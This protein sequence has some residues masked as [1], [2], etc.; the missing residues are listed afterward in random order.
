MSRFYTLIGTTVV[1]GLVG[2][3]PPA[4]AQPGTPLAGEERVRRVASAAPGL[5]EGVV[6][7]ERGHPLGGAMVSALGAI[8]ALA[9]TDRDG[10]FVLRA[11]P[12]GAYLVR[13]HLAGFSRSNRQFV[14]VGPGGVARFSVTLQRIPGP[15]DPPAVL[16]AGVGGASAAPASTGTAG[17]ESD[18]TDA[19][20]SERAWRLRH[21]KRSI[22]KEAERAALD[23]SKEQPA[24]DGTLSFLARALGTSAQFIADLP[25]TAQVNFLT[26]GTFEGGQ[27][28][29]LSG[30]AS[31]RGVAFVT[32]GGPAFHHGDWTA[33]VMGQ[34]EPGS[35]YL[36]G[37]YRKRAPAR[38]L[39]DV[40][41]SYSTQ[42]FTAA[43]R[44]PLDP[45][46]EGQ[47]TAGS[48]YVVDRWKMSPYLTVSYGGRYARYSYLAGGL[49]SPHLNVTLVPVARVRVKGTLS[50]RWLAPG[51]EEFLEPMAAGLWVPPERTFIGLTPVD[52]ERTRHYELTL[53]HDLWRDVVLA[54]SAFVQHTRNQ[55]LALFGSD[56]RPTPTG[57]YVVGNAGNVEAQ[58]WSV[59]LSSTP[60]PGLRGSVAYAMVHGN[61]STERAMWNGLLLAGEKTR[62][63]GE[64]LH[65]LTTSVE[66]RIS[67]TD[68]SLFVAYKLNS[69]FVRREGDA[70]RPG[71]GARFD[72]QVMQG[73]PFLD[74]T[75]AR[76]EVL[77]A[78]RDMFRDQTAGDA[79]VFD[80][81]LVLNPPTR[82]VGGLLVR[83]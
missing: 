52:P 73:L 15:D 30:S 38:H 60:L 61:W 69:G 29:D 45:G 49:V 43:S 83:F 77:V 58:G 35:W 37:T 26:S 22:L 17:E 33:Q 25:L 47:R 21:L 46:G 12:A 41:V 76:W 36:A 39:F 10:E 34:G 1:A 56:L 48:V 75:S 50:Q 27:P 53:E 80:E 8:S 40:G 31:S 5:I 79:S 14:H 51:A 16:A 11:L 74:F 66:T 55:Q 82:V 9:V 23:V 42:Q 13:A 59:G 65:D 28:G 44:W 4:Q 6:M 7:D 57:H 71:L 78:V 67:P 3:S 20:R 62:P 2:W 68:T 70:F 54:V 18:T 72:V 63:A 32:V 64:R 24:D 19:D 81:L